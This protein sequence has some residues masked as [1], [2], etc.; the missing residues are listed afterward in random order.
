M[1]YD[2]RAGGLEGELQVNKQHERYWRGFGIINRDMNKGQ[3]LLDLA[4]GEMTEGFWK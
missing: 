2:V 4:S 1:C 3:S